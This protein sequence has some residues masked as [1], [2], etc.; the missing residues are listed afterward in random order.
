VFIEPY[1]RK[2]LIALS[3]LIICVAQSSARYPN[4]LTPLIA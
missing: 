2:L 3:I 4:F 1:Q